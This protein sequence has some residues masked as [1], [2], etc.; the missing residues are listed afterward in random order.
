MHQ[1]IN[2]ILKYSPQISKEVIIVDNNSNDGTV[3]YL[4]RIFGQDIV[5]IENI[6]NKG[7]G[8]GCNQGLAIANGDFCLFLNPD[9]MIH[10]DCL[11]VSHQ[12]LSAHD[13]VGL[14]GVRMIDEKGAF[15]PESKRHLPTPK[16][17]FFKLFGMSSKIKNSDEAYYDTTSEA[18]D[19]TPVEV[20]TG[21]YMMAR[22]QVLNE[23]H[24]FDE[25]YFMYGEDID[26]SYRSIQAGYRN[27]YLGTQAI[28]HYKGKSSANHQGKIIHHFYEA[29]QIFYDKHYG[30]QDSKLFSSAV[31]MG[32]TFRK[33]L[34]ICKRTFLFFIRPLIDF[35]VFI[36]GFL[37]IKWMWASYYFTDPAYYYDSGINTSLLLY[38]LLWVLIMALGSGYRFYYRKS[39]FIYHVIIGLIII[40]IA[41]ALLDNSWRSSRAI[42][43]LSAVWVLISGLA[44]RSIIQYFH[45]RRLDEKGTKIGLIASESIAEKLQKLINQN[46]YSKTEFVAISSEAVANRLLS[47][48]AG[49]ISDLNYLI[50]LHAIDSIL[51]QGDLLS[52]DHIM[53]INKEQSQKGIQVSIID[54]YQIPNFFSGNQ[55]NRLGIDTLQVSFSINFLEQRIMKRLFDIILSIL[56]L[57]V[58]IFTSVI[59]LSGVGSCLL[60]KNTFIGYNQNDE[61][62]SRLPYVKPGLIPVNDRL[63]GDIKIHR[64]NVAYAMQYSPF[65]DFKILIRQL[66]KE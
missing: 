59:S 7:F 49:S 38:A 62:I 6:E 25:D 18:T 20:L 64:L 37:L 45:S 29:M 54:D 56:L 17:S 52:V 35:V 10:D 3:D 32:I 44:V 4:N 9:T 28:T 66:F 12:Y 5:L 33:W 48:F 43:G 53:A 27:H 16:A 34:S 24:G 36:S 26:I 47:S 13:D 14:L 55:V 39:R 65:L 30:P 19:S 1:C 61:M 41:Y 63:H 15:R 31:S 51:I 60:G 8:K 22:R 42:I 40:L 58:A 57:P 21:A 23:L 50:D 46:T 11:Y 2:S